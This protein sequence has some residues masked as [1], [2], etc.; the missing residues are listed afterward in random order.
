MTIPLREPFSGLSHLLGAVMSIAGLVYML[1]KTSYPSTTQLIAYSVFGLS[2]AMMFSSSA[3]YHLSN[4]DETRLKLYRR[5]DHICIYLMIAGSYTPFCLLVLK[6]QLAWNL[7][8]AIWS[9]AAVGII[10]KIFWLNAPRWLSTGIYVLMGW[11]CMF[12]IGPM[13]DGLPEGGFSWMLAGGLTY[14]FGAVIYALKK[15]N[16]APGFGFHELWHIF[17]LGGAACHFVAIGLYL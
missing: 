7:L 8:I 5:I 9:I 16:I 10:K 1:L 13:I 12:A 17:V 14:T 3:L 6:G 15:P 11:V 4:A 2:M